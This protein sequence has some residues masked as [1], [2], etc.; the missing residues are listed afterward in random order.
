MVGEWNMIM[1]HW[2]NDDERAKPK[3]H[4]EK[5]KVPVPLCSP[6]AARGLAWDRPRNLRSEA[7]D[8]PTDRSTARPKYPKEAL[9]IIDIRFYEFIYSVVLSPYFAA[10]LVGVM[11]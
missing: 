1:Q 7:D 2:W 8:W 3:Y 10:R 6:E 5:K 11:V 4:E 9:Q